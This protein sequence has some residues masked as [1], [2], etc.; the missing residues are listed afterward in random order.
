[1]NLS[2]IKVVV[3]DDTIKLD[4]RLPSRLSEDQVDVIMRQLS[5]Q[6]GDRWGIVKLSG[7][8]VISCVP[9][10]SDKPWNP[11]YGHRGE[12]TRSFRK[13]LAN[14]TQRTVVEPSRG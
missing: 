1:M 9:A 4:Q 8:W 13:A 3:S 12:N 14:A 10:G 5:E 7:A 2:G 6:T 11:V